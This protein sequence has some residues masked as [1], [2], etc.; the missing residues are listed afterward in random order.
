MADLLPFAID[1]PAP[2]ETQDTGASHTV[3]ASD[4]LELMRDRALRAANLLDA[5]HAQLH[6]AT[7]GNAPITAVS[8][9]KGYDGSPEDG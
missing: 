9:S 3:Q 8:M 6:R 5:F 1:R 4:L 7:Q 2:I